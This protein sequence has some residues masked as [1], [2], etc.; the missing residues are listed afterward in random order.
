MIHVLIIIRRIDAVALLF[1]V[2]EVPEPQ[3]LIIAA[4]DCI[5]ACLC[6]VLHPIIQSRNK[7]LSARIPRLI[8]GFHEHEPILRVLQPVL[9]DVSNQGLLLIADKFFE[10]LGVGVSLQVPS[11]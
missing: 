8:G 1:E 4:C 7:D 3:L 2:S 9:V 10:I 6:A 5:S 11:E